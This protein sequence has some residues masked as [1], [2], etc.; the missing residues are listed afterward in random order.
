MY[1]ATFLAFTT[2]LVNSFEVTLQME[3]RALVQQAVML[4]SSLKAVMNKS[5]PDESGDVDLQ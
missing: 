5:A 3:G 4:T 1:A 2:L